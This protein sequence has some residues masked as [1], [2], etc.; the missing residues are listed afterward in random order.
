MFINLVGPLYLKL[1][2]IFLK[3]YETLP[4]ELLEALMGLGMCF[5]GGAYCASIAAVEAFRMTGWD[6]TRRALRDVYEDAKPI[7]EA[8]KADD[9]KDDDGNGKADVL[10]LAPAE[11]LQ[12]KLAVT[13]LAI[14]DPDR[15]MAACG[16]LYTSWLAV[17]G[18]L[19]LQFAK[20]VTL[21]VSI[22][23]ELYA[24]ASRVAVPIL[25]GL[26][27]PKY[28]HWIPAIVRTMLRATAVCIA[29]QLQVV[30]SAVQ[31]A[32]RG[33]TLAA[34]KLIA[35]GN[36]HGLFAIK[37]ADNLDEVVG[38]TLALFGFYTQWQWGFALPFPLNL[39]MFPFTAIE[40]YVRWAVTAN[41]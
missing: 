39:V 11:L 35:Y 24:P 36:K 34:R 38:Y 15:L 41:Y 5:C 27:P 3:A 33:G 7:V 1:W 17:Q 4:I 6:T 20:T 2:A 25:V 9:K 23:N 21:G 30:L 31:S 37:E 29:W 13:A 26:L 12:R 28:H 22:A 8:W 32:L 18:T 40:W 16:G 14:K 19:R 10:Q